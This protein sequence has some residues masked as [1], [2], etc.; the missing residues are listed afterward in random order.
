M[1][2][3]DGDKWGHTAGQVGRRET[4]QQ[5]WTEG[6]CGGSRVDGVRL[7]PLKPPSKWGQDL[8]TAFRVLLNAMRPLP[9]LGSI[10]I[11]LHILCSPRRLQGGLLPCCEQPGHRKPKVPSPAPVPVRGHRCPL[12]GASSNRCQAAPSAGTCRHRRSPA[13]SLAAGEEMLPGLLSSSGGDT[14]STHES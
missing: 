3:S 13:P 8:D 1:T 11:P 4:G 14:K 10:A 7:C 6:R 12:A 9:S 2:G 5:G